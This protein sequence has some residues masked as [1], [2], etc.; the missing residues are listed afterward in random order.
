MFR[1]SIVFTAIGISLAACG[2][3]GGGGG[4]TEPDVVE[5]TA[6]NIGSTSGVAAQTGLPFAD[7]TAQSIP[8]NTPLTIRLARFETDHASGQTRLIVSTETY[9]KAAGSNLLNADVEIEG[10]TVTLVYDSAEDESFGSLSNGQELGAYI[11]ASGQF[12]SLINVFTYEDPPDDGFDS[13]GTFAAGFE[14]DPSSLPTFAGTTDYTGTLLG[15]ANVVDQNGNL[16][17]QE[18]LLTGDAAIAVRFADGRVGGSVDTQAT[19]LALTYLDDVLV[20]TETDI[21]GNGFSTDASTLQNCGGCTSESLV[22]GAFFGANAEELGGILALDV[23][24]AAGT[25]QVIGVGGFIA[26]R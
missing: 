23:T 1:N 9:T 16:I 10:A 17:E 18:V 8:A 11:N 7:G 24:N 5:I 6:L 15:F 12:V 2:G 22:G 3:G 4:S 13:E 14:T 19:G 20:L 25:Q 21:A 26:E